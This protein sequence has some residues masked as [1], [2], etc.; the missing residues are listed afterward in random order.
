MGNNT[1]VGMV[2]LNF[3][4][5]KLF[6]DIVAQLPMLPNFL[7]TQATTKMDWA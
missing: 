4:I 6:W 2:Y 3:K 1:H 7:K 5:L